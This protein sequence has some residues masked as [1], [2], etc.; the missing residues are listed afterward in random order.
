MYDTSYYGASTTS[1]I[2]LITSIF[3]SGITII[4]SLGYSLLTIASLWKIFEKFGKEGWKSIIPIYN[5]IVLFE[6]VDMKP[7]YVALVLIP[8]VGPLVLMVFMIIAYARLAKKFGKDGMF[9]LLIIFFTPIA[10]ALLAFGKNNIENN[11][12]NNNVNMQNNYQP[13]MDTMNQVPPMQEMNQ[14]IPPVNM[15][16]NQM[17]NNNISP[18]SNIV[19]EQN[20]M[21]NNNME[22]A[23]VGE[24]PPF[25][26][27]EVQPVMDN[28][29]PAMNEI[30]NTF[31]QP[32]QNVS[33]IIENNTFQEA[34]VV[35][36]V[37]PV[38]LNNSMPVETPVASAVNP[39][40]Q[41]VINNNASVMNEVPNMFNQPIPEP[42]Q[43][44]APITE[45]TMNNNMEST[46]IMDPI[47]PAVEEQQSIVPPMM[48]QPEVE[49]NT[50]NQ[51]PDPLQN[52]EPPIIPTINDNDSNIQ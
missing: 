20:L 2:S 6:I 1:P 11:A 41:P 44:S 25:S 24:V 3:S 19:P 18:M 26:T 36:D 42:I 12:Q 31:E 32:V 39:E 34:K 47:A 46:M 49:P 8:C 23:P 45:N 51:A 13:M 38:T 10:L 9:V 30:P 5:I 15:M 43:P 22:A 33:P 16:D 14:Q 40:V 52:I 48:N 35:E 37:Q 27:P 28:N 21:Q 7:W 4:I 29:A 50:N 17:V